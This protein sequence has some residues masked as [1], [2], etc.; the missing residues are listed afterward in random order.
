M[1]SSS[2]ADYPAPGTPLQCHRCSKYIGES[3]VALEIVAVTK[4][5]DIKDTVSRPREVFTCRCGWFNVF[6]PTRLALAEG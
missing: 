2:A 1:P 4:D 6:K 5:R 3:S